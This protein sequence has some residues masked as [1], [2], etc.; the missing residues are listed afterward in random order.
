MTRSLATIGVAASLGAVLMYLLDPRQGRRRRALIRD[1]VNSAL[2]RSRRSLAGRA[3]D[4]RNRLQ[5]VQAESR[6]AAEDLVAS[7]TPQDEP[8]TPAV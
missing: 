4:V 7:I 1:E 2:V 3:Q 8:S 6:R 5:G